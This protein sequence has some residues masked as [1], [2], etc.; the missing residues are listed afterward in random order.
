M[1]EK[2]KAVTFNEGAPFDPNDLNQ[3]Q[4]NLT[5]VFTT[6]KSLLNATR[7]SSG[8]NRVAIVDQGFVTITLKGTTPVNQTVTF[9]SSFVAGT[10]TGFVASVGQALTAALGI[11]SVSAVKNS[12][13][14]GGTIYVAT[15]NAKATGDIK[16]NWMAAQLKTI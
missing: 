10:D 3:L 16:I 15:S 13:G 1:T 8:Q 6:S 7:D 14:T 9:T 11:V 4:S 2:W 5:D 12:T